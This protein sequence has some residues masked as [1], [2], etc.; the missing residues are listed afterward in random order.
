MQNTQNQPHHPF[1]WKPENI[2]YFEIF[3]EK[4]FLD[5]LTLPNNQLKVKDLAQLKLR[6]VRSPRKVRLENLRKFWSLKIRENK[7]LQKLENVKSA[8]SN[9]R[10]N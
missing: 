5:D 3:P 4:K 2:V 10:E 8:K 9:H 1:A 6:T 7:Y